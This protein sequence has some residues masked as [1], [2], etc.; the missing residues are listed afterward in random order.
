MAG[1]AQAVRDRLV[2][3]GYDVPVID[4]AIMAIKMA[5]VLVDVG[6]S[7]SKLAY[8]FP[9]EKPVSGYPSLWE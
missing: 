6:L 2:Q 3:H 7:H 1:M 4:P 8:P 5:A 9:P